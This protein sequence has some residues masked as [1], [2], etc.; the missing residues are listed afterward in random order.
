MFT[1]A[2]EERGSIGAAVFGL[3]AGGLAATWLLDIGA[4]L[5]AETARAIAQHS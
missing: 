1:P 2:P 4:V 3:S 5:D